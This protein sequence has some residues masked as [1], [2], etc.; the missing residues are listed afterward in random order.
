L[1]EASHT[2][3]ISELPQHVHTLLASNASANGNSPTN[4]TPAQPTASIGAIYGPAVAPA[5]STMS[6]KVI[7]LAGNSLPHN[8]MQPYLVITF[9]IALQGIFP[10]QN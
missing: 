9:C 4:A 7:G 3:N 2:L 10:T 6:P 1:G 5:T 8:N